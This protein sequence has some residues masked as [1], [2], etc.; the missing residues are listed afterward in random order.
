MSK[1]NIKCEGCNKNNSRK[2]LIRFDN[3]LTDKCMCINCIVKSMCDERLMLY[4]G[5]SDGVK[6]NLNCMREAS[7]KKLQELHSVRRKRRYRR[8]IFK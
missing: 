2:C 7:I 1:L 3:T 4:V 5:T 6:S 8:I